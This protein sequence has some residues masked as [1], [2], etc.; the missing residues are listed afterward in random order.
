ML[1]LIE[2]PHRL[3]GNVFELA[4]GTLF[5]GEACSGVQSLFTML[6]CSM[7]LVAW[8][9][10]RITLLPIYLLAAVVW[11]GCL[12]V[13]RIVA[14][15]VAQEWFGIDLLHGWKHDLLGYTCLGLAIGLLASTD[16]LIQVL[17][18]PVPASDPSVKFVFWEQLWNSVFATRDEN[19]TPVDAVESWRTGH[20]PVVESQRANSVG[21]APGNRRRMLAVMWFG[22]PSAPTAGRNATDQQANRSILES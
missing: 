11:A 7:F 9:R 3:Q 20:N 8:L 21:P 19:K 16:R 15:A 5:I 17:A 12:N 1:D 13:M 14:I 4:S 2:V 6:F 18:F 10:R 22:I